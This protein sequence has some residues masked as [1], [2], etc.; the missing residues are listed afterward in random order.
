MEYFGNIEALRIKL[1]PRRVETKY[2]GL[3]LTG[4]GDR[5]EVTTDQLRRVIEE[6]RMEISGADTILVVSSVEGAAE[7]KRVERGIGSKLA[8][9]MAHGVSVAVLKRNMDVFF[10]Q[11]KVILQ[12]GCDRIGEFQISE[13]EVCAQ[14]SGEGQVAL[15]GS[16]AKIEAQGGIKFTLCRVPKTA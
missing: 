3:V 2:A 15:M 5:I 11:I 9:T 16:G 7:G 14:I 1:A 8:S 10:D 12:N 13:I 4:F 6:E